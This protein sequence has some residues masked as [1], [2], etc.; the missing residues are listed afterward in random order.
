MS[1]R[2]GELVATDEPTVIA[3]SQFDT[4]FVED[5]QS[6]GCL[7]NSA[8]TNESNWNEFVSE[9]D[10]LLDQLVASIEGPR[11]WG[12]GFSRYARFE[13]KIMDPLMVQIADLI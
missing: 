9:I 4:I 3:E 10:Y 8:S 12:P 1:T 11:W 6:G 2:G 5:C 13:Y 7:A